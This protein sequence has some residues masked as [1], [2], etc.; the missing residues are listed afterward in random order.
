MKWKQDFEPHILE[1]GLSYLESESVTDYYF[2][3]NTII[4]TVLGSDIYDVEIVNPFSNDVTYFCTCPY[5]ELDNCKHM[6]AVLYHFETNKSVYFNVDVITKEINNIDYDVLKEWTI[7]ICKKDYAK[8][9]S[10]IAL[11]E[12][13]KQPVVSYEKEMVLFL[14]KYRNSN[15]D[16]LILSKALSNEV[17]AFCDNQ[18]NS[19]VKLNKSYTIQLSFKL[20]DEILKLNIA[21]DSWYGFEIISNLS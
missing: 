4:A 19:L 7:A 18:L 8:L 3:D 15:I 14:N 20:L 16:T 12:Y 5:A 2:E 21:L 1:R 9:G 17:E 13:N 6:A 11:N 10:L